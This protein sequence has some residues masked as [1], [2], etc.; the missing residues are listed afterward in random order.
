[1]YNSVAGSG[2][3]FQASEFPKQVASSRLDCVALPRTQG[4]HVKAAQIEFKDPWA[5]REFDAV[6]IAERNFRK[7]AWR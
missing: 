3:G 1:M 5:R 2:P 4:W 7:F 6:S